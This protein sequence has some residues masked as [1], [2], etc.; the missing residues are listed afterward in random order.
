MDR[1][2]SFAEAERFTIFVWLFA[3]F[4]LIH[5]II[6]ARHWVTQGPVAIGGSVVAML[7][8]AAVLAAPASAWRVA[9][10]AGALLVVKIDAMPYTPNH[11]LFTSLICLGLLA[12]AGVKGRS[13]AW[14]GVGA[15]TIAPAVRLALCIV[16][17]FA[18]LHKLN[19]DYF[20]PAVSCGP[21]LFRELRGYLT[22]LPAGAWIDWP[23]ILG[24]LATEGVLGLLLLFRR[25]RTPA[26]ALGLLFH[27]LL[28]F[29]PNVY[30]MSFSTLIIPLYALFLPL[31]FYA[32]IAR[33]AHR[34]P[35]S[36]TSPPAMLRHAPLAAVAILVAAVAVLIVR[37]ANPDPSSRFELVANALGPA[38]RTLALAFVFGAAGVFFVTL[39]VAPAGI[40]DRD[41]PRVPPASI[42]PAATL[43]TLVTFNG[44]CPYLGF[45][46]QT[47]FSMFSN[48]RTEMG[49]TNHFFMP[50]LGLTGT[51]RNLVVVNA[52]SHRRLA[53]YQDTGE[54]IPFFEVQRAAAD[55][56]AGFTVLYTPMGETEPLLA[57]RTGAS[58]PRAAAVFDTPPLLLRKVIG[59][60]PVPP[61]DKP[62]GCRH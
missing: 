10:M 22:F 45:K 26:I 47:S 8:I 54:L 11:V 40:L 43:A 59:F 5:E 28:A 36:I 37:D 42:W 57:T 35:R 6:D 55:N 48:L 58:D 7:A 33:I 1:P 49:Q 38:P 30:I 50:S 23:A 32:R 52:T 61:L 29:H 16:Y 3:A 17:G 19:S 41:E 31:D 9:L 18:V 53:R 56:D 62:C 34:L 44:L 39:A 12:L 21:D 24:S 25:T 20:D 51:T 46:T 14:T 60:R 27:G 15:A 4:S 2:A 13:R